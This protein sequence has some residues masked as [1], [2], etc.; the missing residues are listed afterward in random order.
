MASPGALEFG[1]LGLAVAVAGPV[2]GPWLVVVL[3]ACVGSL[4][5]LTAKAREPDAPRV[6]ALGY[7]LMGALLAF[8]LIGPIVGIVKIFYKDVPI[9]PVLVIASFAIGA[10]RDSVLALLDKLLDGVGGAWGTFL[11]A[12]AARKG[13][14]DN[15]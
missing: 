12:M 4:L 15:K 5:A 2:L 8:M 7:V 6:K 14:G 13:G 9:E 10:R 11:S 3:S 1:V